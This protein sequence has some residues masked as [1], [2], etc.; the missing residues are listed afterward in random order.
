MKK[1]KAGK[2]D[3]QAG[4]DDQRF[5]HLKSDPK[6]SGLSNKNKKVC[7]SFLYLIKIV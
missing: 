3:V 1:G 2:K 6:F 5:A 4:L 7:F